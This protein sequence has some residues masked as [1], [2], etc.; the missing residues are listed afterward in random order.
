MRTSH[1]Y[2]G[3]RVSSDVLGVDNISEYAFPLWEKVERRWTREGASL[4]GSHHEKKYV[5]LSDIKDWSLV[6]LSTNLQEL[7]FCTSAQQ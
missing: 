2:T 1:S 7:D 4:S 3:V 6:F 5:F